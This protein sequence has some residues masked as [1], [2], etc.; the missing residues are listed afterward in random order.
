MAGVTKWV[1]IDIV[2]DVVAF[3]AAVNIDQRLFMASR[4]PEIHPAR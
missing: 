2:I 4:S 3:D 1:N